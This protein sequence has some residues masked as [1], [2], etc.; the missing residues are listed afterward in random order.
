M[1]RGECFSYIVN[2]RDTTRNQSL[3]LSL[4]IGSHLGTPSFN[5][6]V[7]FSLMALLP[8]AIRPYPDHERFK[9]HISRAFNRSV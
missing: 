5:K 6:R 4:D 2:V 9:I 1:G 8:E 3:K 7:T